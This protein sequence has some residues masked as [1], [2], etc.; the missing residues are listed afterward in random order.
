MILFSF[1]FIDINDIMPGPDCI[2]S[3]DSALITLRTSSYDI[4][5]HEHRLRLYS[6][7][8][9]VK[10]QDQRSKVTTARCS[11]RG[12]SRTEVKALSTVHHIATLQQSTSATRVLNFLESEHSD[13]LA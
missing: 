5:Y 9:H 3:L 12:S 11:T 13:Q 2:A 7:E 8:K 6:Q 4:I 1:H 10:R